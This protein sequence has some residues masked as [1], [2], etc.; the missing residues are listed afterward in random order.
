MKKIIILVAFAILAN[1][2]CSKAKTAN[3]NVNSQ[4]V[5][6]NS[7][8]LNSSPNLS[9]S[10]QNGTSETKSEVNAE[11]LKQIE[12]QQLET[13]DPRKVTKQNTANTNQTVKKSVPPG[14]QN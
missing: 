3:S 11:M 2:A 12:A 5:L 4:T 1:A 10:N 6:T 8:N 9:L 14:M 13:A 7:P